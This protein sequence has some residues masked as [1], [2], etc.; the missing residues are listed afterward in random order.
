MGLKAAA[1]K[2]KMWTES[3]ILPYHNVVISYLVK[4]PY[5]CC[6]SGLNPQNIIFSVQ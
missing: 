2:K 5:A 6:S 1:E 4:L 3:Q